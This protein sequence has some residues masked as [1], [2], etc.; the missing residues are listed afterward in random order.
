MC[1]CAVATCGDASIVHKWTGI[2]ACAM[3]FYNCYPGPPSG[4]YRVTLLRRLVVLDIPVWQA[5]SILPF[6]L[7]L[8]ALRQRVLAGFCSALFA[9]PH[10]C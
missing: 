2:K 6:N 4:Y 3:D 8:E 5:V 7:R 1:V 9:R 10:L